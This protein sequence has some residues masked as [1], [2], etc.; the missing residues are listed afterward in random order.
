MDLLGR[1]Y[2]QNFVS[3]L[4]IDSLITI[5]P[6][7]VLDLGV[8]DASLTLS[9]YRRWE[10]A[11]FYATEI[12][13]NKVEELG[14]KLSFLQIFHC[15]TLKPSIE[16]EIKSKF[17]TIDVAICNPPY[18][19]IK[20]S[21][22]YKKL[23]EDADCS[24]FLEM[25]QITSEIVFFAH[26]ITLLKNDGELGIIVSDSLITGKNFKIFREIVLS[27]FN[28][29]SIIQLPD[30]IFHKTEARTHILILAKKPSISTTCELFTTNENGILSKK[31][32]VK[33]E[34]LINRMDYKFFLN[35]ETLTTNLPTLKSINAD[36]RRG[37]TSYKDLR[38]KNISYFH[39]IHLGND[40]ERFIF[41]DDVV[42]NLIYTSA[43]IGDILMCRVGKRCV[44]KL[45]FVGK[46][47]IVISD[48]IYKISVDKK[49]QELVW[50]SLMSKK[51]KLWI[52]S[53]SHGVCSQLISKCDLINFPLFALNNNEI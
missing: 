1:Y 26:N 23:F 47:E 46:G 22:I 39:S 32:V 9:A 10:N 5:A 8:G 43:G 53:Y 27:K 35:E 2:T 48:C 16:N 20:D 12:E 44:G 3:D 30:K 41:N 45:G 37:K 33:K 6:Q 21:T 14:K 18:V 24:S 51:G 19:K 38:T 13:Q 29:T 11:Q 36:I 49:Y 50:N 25:K 34:C 15:D 31:I 28:L 42:D 40:G 17:G 4:L 52:K 7:K